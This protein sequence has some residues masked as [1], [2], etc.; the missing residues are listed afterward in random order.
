MNMMETENTSPTSFKTKYIDLLHGSI[1]LSLEQ[2]PQNN[3]SKLENFAEQQK[4]RDDEQQQII[5]RL[6]SNM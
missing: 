4:V 1:P 3:L 6:K 5:E 2:Q